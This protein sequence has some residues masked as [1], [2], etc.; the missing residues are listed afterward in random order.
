MRHYISRILWFTLSFFLLIILVGS[1]TVVAETDSNMA[2]GGVQTSCTYNASEIKIGKSASKFTH[3]DEL[4]NNTKYTGGA[5]IASEDWL[6][7]KLPRTNVSDCTDQTPVESDIAYASPATP[8]ANTTHTVAPQVNEQVTGLEQLSVRYEV[9]PQFDRGLY[10]NNI[11]H[12]GIDENSDGFIEKSLTDAVEYVTVPSSNTVQFSL[13]GNVTLPAD[14]YLV[15]RYDGIRNPDYADTYEV[16]T[17][18]TGNRTVNNNGSIRFGENLNRLIGQ[19]DHRYISAV[20]KNGSRL[21]TLRPGKTAFRNDSMQIFLPTQSNLNQPQ[22]YSFTVNRSRSGL[23]LS[24]Q[25]HNVKKNITVFNR[26]IQTFSNAKIKNGTIE[27]SGYTNI[28]PDSL[29]SVQV[30]NE[31]RLRE[32]ETTVKDSQTWSIKISLP[33]ELL[34]ASTLRVNVLDYDRE[35]L[36]RGILFIETGKQGRNTKPSS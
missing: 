10:R 6:A 20:S 8:N 3:I 4:V 28:A 26:Y 2:D 31:G 30:F 15:V 12:F 23:S 22:L 18:I 32:A 7:L 1:G 13:N 16:E 25:P 33:D 29:I 21:T 24:G 17:T 11:T 36:D 35:T 14:S 19:S 34:N 27:I 9:G 5:H